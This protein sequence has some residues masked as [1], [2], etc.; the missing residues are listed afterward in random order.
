MTDMV[1]TFIQGT[2]TPLGYPVSQTPGDASAQT[3]IT[4]NLTSGRALPAANEWTRVRHM[5]QLHAYTHGQ[6]SEHRTAFFA[7]IDALRAHGVRI[8]SWG[9]D[10]YEKD[11]GICHIACTCVWNQ[12]EGVRS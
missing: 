12:R 9:G 11:T 3:W 8:F 10:E 6:E 7:A 5:F 1:E 4:W 2:L